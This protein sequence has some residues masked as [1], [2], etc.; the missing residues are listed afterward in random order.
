MVRR[1]P[2]VT[3]SMNLLP[4]SSNRWLI[5]ALLFPLIF[6][7]G[8]LLVRILEFF[9]PIFSI[10]ML[11]AVLAFI[12]NYPVHFLEKR[13]LKRPIAAMLVFLVGGIILVGLGATLLPALSQQLAESG[14]LLPGLIDTGSQEVEDLYNS[15]SRNLPADV[16]RLLAQLRDHLF[17]GLQTLVEHLADLALGTLNNASEALLAIVLTFYILLDGERLWHGL[18]ARMPLPFGKQIQQSLQQNFHHYFVGQIALSVLVG[19]VMTTIFLLL[20]VPYA[21][22]F[23]LSIGIFALIPFG[24]LISFALVSLLIA[25]QDLGLAAKVLV[26]GILSDQVVDQVIAPRILGHFTGL[27]PIWVI[28]ALLTGAKLGGLL[29]LLVAVPIASFIKDAIEGFPDYPIAETDPEAPVTPIT[30]N[31]ATTTL[32]SGSGSSVL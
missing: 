10:L 23:G 20:H 21:L 7:N 29:G 4:S 26:L 3:A 31:G 16:A 5:L 11:A 17:N 19:T 22:L 8:W 18:F 27:R 9:Q 25:A 32:T 28:V 30:E 2:L 14:K 1:L 13:G 6:L 15:I 24:D 12:L